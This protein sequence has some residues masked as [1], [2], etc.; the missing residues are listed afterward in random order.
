M[1][2]SVRIEGDT[3]ALRK[4]IQ[5]STGLE[6]FSTTL[7]WDLEDEFPPLLFKIVRFS[8]RDAEI[9]P[10]Q[11]KMWTRDNSWRGITLIDTSKGAML[12]DDKEPEEMR[13][14]LMTEMRLR[15]I[16][17]ALWHVESNNF[18]L[19]MLFHRLNQGFSIR[20]TPNLRRLLRRGTGTYVADTQTAVTF[21]PQRLLQRGIQ[22][23][24]KLLIG[25]MIR[26][27]RTTVHRLF[28]TR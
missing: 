13:R 11:A 1:P 24:R 6:Q 4:L 27:L 21:A 25:Q 19:A 18:R 20:L 10:F 9:T 28:P 12:L 16:H 23:Y 3:E 17:R 22:R 26:S 5:T 15:K 14:E 2:V 7:K 8:I